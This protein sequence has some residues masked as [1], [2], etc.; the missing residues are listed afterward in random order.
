[1]DNEMQTKLREGLQ[2]LEEASEE[3]RDRL[4]LALIKLHGAL[5][6]YLHFELSEK[7]PHLRLEAQ[8]VSQ[9]SWQDLIRYG[10]Q[11]LG[12]SEGDAR[13]ISDADRQHQH[14]ARG[15]A[16]AKSR[17]ELVEYADFVKRLYAEAGA[18][19]IPVQPVGAAP[20]AAGAAPGLFT[21]PE[22][23]ERRQPRYR[24]SLLLI[25]Y[26]AAFLIFFCIVGFLSYTDTFLEFVRKPFERPTP[27]FTP[28]GTP[29]PL[30]SA[31]LTTLPS[32]T[33]AV[34]NPNTACVIVWVEHPTDLGR[35]TRSWVYEQLVSD[36]V[37]GT[38]MTPREFY[39]Q[40]VEHNPVLEADDYEFK[41]GITYLLPQCQ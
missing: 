5:G 3:D 9:T 19:G 20:R 15:G 14:V 31:T 29:E 18:P 8:D 27:Q 22:S 25:A 37:K 23:P 16:Y 21:S 11:Y 39:D 2:I 24:S 13:M 38:G 10:Q 1:M 7:A 33:L 17:A 30:P 35:K 32:P 36:Q 6:D 26:F 4:G 12:F 40:V 28:T 34:A 41:S